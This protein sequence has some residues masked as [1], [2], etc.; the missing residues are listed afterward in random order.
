MSE[1]KVVRTGNDDALLKKLKDDPSGHDFK[2]FCLWG[3]IMKY[4]EAHT[5]SLRCRDQLASLL[6]LMLTSEHDKYKDLKGLI[7]YVDKR[8]P[9]NV[10]GHLCDHVFDLDAEV[11]EQGA[12]VEAMYKKLADELAGSEAA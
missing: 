2:G 8:A 6:I 4:A 11:D 5:G 12:Y 1:P 10:A 9:Y 3:R 7:K